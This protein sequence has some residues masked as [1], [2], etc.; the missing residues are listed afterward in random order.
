MLCLIS[1]RRDKVCPLYRVRNWDDT[2]TLQPPRKLCGP[3]ENS[4]TTSLPDF[5]AKMVRFWPCNSKNTAQAFKPRLFASL[6]WNA[7]CSRRCRTSGINLHWQTRSEE[8]AYPSLLE[9][10]IPQFSTVKTSENSPMCST[11]TLEGPEKLVGDINQV[12]LACPQQDAAY[13]DLVPLITS[14]QMNQNGQKRSSSK[15][16]QVWLCPKSANRS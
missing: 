7:E 13:S 10:S 16:E 4:C 11:W 5:W 14:V 9:P 2:N 15:P 8:I 1:T 12:H 6:S 3:L